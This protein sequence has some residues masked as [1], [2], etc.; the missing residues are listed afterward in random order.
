MVGHVRHLGVENCTTI[1]LQS[2]ERGNQ[3]LEPGADERLTWTRE[4]MS[5]KNNTSDRY[6]CYCRYYS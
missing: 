1:V 6:L 5:T 3:L 4:E 2:P